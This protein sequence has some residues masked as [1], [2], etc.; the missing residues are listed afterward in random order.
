MIT[1][2]CRDC[3]NQISSKSALYGLGRCKKCARTGENHPNYIDGRSKAEHFCKECNKKVNRDSVFYRSRSG[4]CKSCVKKGERHPNFGKKMSKETRLKIGKAN[5]GRKW[6]FEARLKMS[7]FRIGKYKG[8]NSPN[9]GKKL[10]LEQ[11]QK[12][13]KATKGKNNPRWLGGISFLPYTSNFSDELKLKIRERDNFTCQHCDLK[14]KNHFRANKQ[15]NLTVHHI[16]Y[17]KEN[18]K[19]NNLITVCNICNVKA[20]YNRD[21]W[22]AY[23]TYLMESR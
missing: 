5:K 12:I 20:N 3:G 1:Y 13:S 17:N 23:Y 4:L 2:C 7:K 18:C 9:F 15:I 6:S 11:R 8:I 16:D 10:S 19:K 14:E 21:Y 22:Y